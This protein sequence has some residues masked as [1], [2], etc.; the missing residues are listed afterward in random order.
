MTRKSQYLLEIVGSLSDDLLYCPGSI[1]RHA[2]ERGLLAADDKMGRRR[3]RGALAQ[4]IP[5]GMGKTQGNAKVGPGLYRAWK[6]S[7]WKQIYF[8]GEK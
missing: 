7:R 2:I 8:G 6:G 4:Y 5:R 1:A 3:I